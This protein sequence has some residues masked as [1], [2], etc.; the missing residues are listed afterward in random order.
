MPFI[1]AEQAVRIYSSTVRLCL[2]VELQF[3]SRTMFLWNGA[4]RVTL[5]SSTWE[6]VGSMGAIDGLMQTREPVSTKV[7]MSLSG[8]S[9]EVLALAKASVSD[10]QGRAAYVWLQLMD[11]AWQPVGARLPVFWGIM[12]RINIKR[13]EAREDGVDRICELEVENPFYGRSRP[14]AGRY[15]DADQQSKY[16]GDR[17]FRF[18]PVQ[19]SQTITWPD[20]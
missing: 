2:L 13:A 9:Q 14:S 4:G 12:Q 18:I 15:N 20:Y 19:K 3:A 10:V 6:G 16:P 17:F 8:V 1:T 5:Y 11:S 7:T